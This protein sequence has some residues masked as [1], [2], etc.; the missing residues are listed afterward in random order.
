MVYRRSTSAYTTVPDANVNSNEHR[1]CYF[2]PPSVAVL[3]TPTLAAAA[4]ALELVLPTTAPDSN[5]APQVFCTTQEIKA[6][7]LKDLELTVPRMP[8]VYSAPPS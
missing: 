7:S 8:T 2:R 1:Y 3:P 5:K 6:Q 4:P